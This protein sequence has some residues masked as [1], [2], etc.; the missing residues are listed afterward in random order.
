LSP[1]DVSK[2]ILITGGIKC[3]KS[4]YALE[5]AAETAGD[6]VFLATAEALDGDMKRKI[7]MHQLERDGSFVTVEEPIYLA[8]TLN[9]LTRQPELI[10]IDCLTL[11]VSNLIHHFDDLNEIRQQKKLFLDQVQSID[12]NMIIVTNEVGLGVMPDNP[13]SRKYVDE[14]GLLNQEV[15]GLCDEVIMVVSG[16]PQKIKG[17]NA[18][19]KME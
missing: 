9:G 16:L 13:L 3:G 19:A 17:H 7:A 8:K 6:K 14:I 15:A 18:Y 12:T 2:K 4:R 11:W 10:L 1:M 5:R